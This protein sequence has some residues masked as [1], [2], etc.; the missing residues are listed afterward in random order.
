MENTTL[1]ALVLAGLA[2]L[3]LYFNRHVIFQ[4]NGGEDGPMAPEKKIFLLLIVLVPLLLVG[5]YIS[6]VGEQIRQM[7][8]PGYEPVPAK[9][10]PYRNEPSVREEGFKI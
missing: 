5:L 8:V 6:K 2:G 4:K 1:G 3:L 7:D 10:S 9:P